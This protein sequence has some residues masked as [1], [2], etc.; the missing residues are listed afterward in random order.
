MTKTAQQI[1]REQ[2]Q[3]KNRQATARFNQ[4]VSDIE[5]NPEIRPKGL[6]ENAGGLALLGLNKINNFG[7][8]VN[9]GVKGLA[10]LAY[11]NDFSG[12]AE[13]SPFPATTPDTLPSLA[14]TAPAAPPP[15]A[16]KL[17]APVPTAPVPVKA[18]LPTLPPEQQQQQKTTQGLQSAIQEQLTPPPKGNGQAI[19]SYGPGI[20]SQNA[21]QMIGLMNMITGNDNDS[22]AV[23]AAK[24]SAYF[25]RESPKSSLPELA[26]VQAAIT[27]KPANP[28]DYAQVLSNTE[29]DANGIK[30]TIQRLVD[31]RD[32]ANFSPAISESQSPVLTNAQK[33]QRYWNIANALATKSDGTPFSDNEKQQ[34]QT[35][36]EAMRKQYGV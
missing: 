13:G 3:L 27:P 9:A 2:E 22:D 11:T 19:E 8:A 35:E 5:A 20:P 24:L 1:A 18:V 10:N 29:E 12:G 17:P 31:T 16:T 6:F 36:F 28:K 25:G 32:P 30:K 15:T 4:G 23:K 33:M 14:T 21:Y 34:A 7:N 26:A